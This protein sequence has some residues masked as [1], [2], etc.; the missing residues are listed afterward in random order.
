[1]RGEGKNG[2][3]T[4]ALL[5]IR[6]RFMM[7]RDRKGGNIGEGEYGQIG[8]KYAYDVCVCVCSVLM[9]A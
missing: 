5:D 8:K 9:C 4:L 6:I 7:V 1:M 3:P 2:P